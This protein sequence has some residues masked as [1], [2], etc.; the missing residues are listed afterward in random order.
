MIRDVTLLENT[1]GEWRRGGYIDLKKAMVMTEK[2]AFY[3]ACQR[4]ILSKFPISDATYASIIYNVE[5]TSHVNAGGSGN[6]QKSVAASSDSNGYLTN[7]NVKALTA[8]VATPNPHNSNN[9]IDTPPR[10]L[11]RDSTR[12]ASYRDSDLNS[13]YHQGSS[14]LASYRQYLRLSRDSYFEPFHEA[15]LNEPVGVDQGRRTISRGSSCG[16]TSGISL[17]G[18]G[19]GAGGNYGVNCGGYYV[20]GVHYSVRDSGSYSSNSNSPNHTLHSPTP[21]HQNDAETAANTAVNSKTPKKAKKSF[22]SPLASFFG[23]FRSGS[24]SNSNN[25][26]ASHKG[27]SA[28]KKAAKYTLVADDLELATLQQYIQW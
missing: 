15:Q 14:G 4:R 23:V 18:F 19:S 3:L 20:D 6:G 21:T 10:S 13:S 12:S 2:I 8:A 24:S 9:V 7:E 27:S 22:L 28:R 25:S 16:G 5:I 17:S 11:S 1:S 26:A